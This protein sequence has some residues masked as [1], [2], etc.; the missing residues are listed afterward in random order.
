MPVSLERFF[1]A[2]NARDWQRYATFLHPD[3]TWALVDD[4]VERR[5]VGREEY[6]R[7]IQ[8]AYDGV[9]TTF[10]CTDTRVDTG[11]FR[12]ASLLISDTGEPGCV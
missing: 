1:A 9:S 2:E 4:D 8:R 5:V 11:R 12:V 7:V 10:R 6:L 3:V